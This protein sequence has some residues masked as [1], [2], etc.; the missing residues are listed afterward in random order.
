M[1]EG[2]HAADIGAVLKMIFITRSGTLHKGKGGG[3][4]LSPGRRIFPLVGPFSAARRSIIML[5]IMA[6]EELK[7][8]LVILLAS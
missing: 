8:K 4:L 7:F 5:V 6:L 2:G 1:L 3:S